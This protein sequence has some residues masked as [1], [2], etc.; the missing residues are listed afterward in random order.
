M[1]STL[2]ST[3]LAGSLL[4]Q[5]V[6]V[7][8]VVLDSA[9]RLPLSARVAIYGDTA[10]PAISWTLTDSSG[11]F[12]FTTESQAAR[13]IEVKRIGYLPLRLPLTRFARRDSIV[14]VLGQRPPEIILDTFEVTAHADRTL[15]KAGFYERKR[16]YH[17]T[18]WDSTEVNRNH[19]STL[20]QLLRPYLKGCTRIFVD[21]VAFTRLSD[22][23][24]ETVVGIEIYPSNASAPMQYFN[25]AESMKRC[26]SIVVWRAN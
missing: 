17:G 14:I 26:G 8:G 5:G 4:A 2:F 11:R 15:N 18:F 6:P 13:L 19:P 12:R 22:V 7:R 20:L 3:F 9:T 10:R 25:P 16:A 23:P 1:L 21:G 24:I